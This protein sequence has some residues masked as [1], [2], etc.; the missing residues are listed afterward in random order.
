MKPFSR[1]D[2][3]GLK[4]DNAPMH[5]D[6]TTGCDHAGNHTQRYLSPFPRDCRLWHGGHAGDAPVIEIVTTLLVVLSV[7]VFVA[8]A[9]DAYRMG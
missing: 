7:G 1:A 3:A 9:F 4:Q 2:E 6:Q 5:P 8:H